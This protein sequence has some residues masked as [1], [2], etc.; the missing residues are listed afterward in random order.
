M[1]EC[2]RRTIWIE[3]DEL[4]ALRGEPFLRVMPQLTGKN[5]EHAVELEIVVD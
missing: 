4:L 1:P 3:G 5:G 2:S